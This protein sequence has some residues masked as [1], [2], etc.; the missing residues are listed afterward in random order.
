MNLMWEIHKDIPR[1]GPGDN[2]S[3][4]KALKMLRDLPTT[5]RILD[6]GCGPGMQTIELAKCSNGQVTGID[7]HQPYL[8]TLE[9]NAKAEGISGRIT[10]KK[11]SMFEINYEKGS[12]DLIWSEGAIYIIGFERGIREWK[13]LLK[14]GGYLVASEISWLRNDSPEEAKKFWNNDYPDMSSIS[15]NIKKI[16]D[17]GYLPVGHFILPERSW[18]EYYYNPL[19]ERVQLLK[20]KYAGNEEALN[21]LAETEY[22]AEI[23]RKY[24]DYYGYVFYLMQKTK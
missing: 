23:Y 5:P 11:K 15:G 9:S 13:D 3:T 17:T 12:L 22:E 7:I 2:D 18:W 16:E 10:A 20:D 4:K 19:L 8:D 14:G 21:Q 24:S 1:E 6:I